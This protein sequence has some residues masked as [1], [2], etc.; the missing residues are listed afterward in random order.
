MSTFTIPAREVK[1]GSKVMVETVGG[2]TITGNVEHNNSFAGFLEFEDG[3]I[4]KYHAISRVSISPEERFDKPG[5]YV[6]YG[7]DLDPDGHMTCFPNLILRTQLDKK[8]FRIANSGDFIKPLPE[9]EV[10]YHSMLPL[11]IH[12]DYVGG[13]K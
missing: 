7:Y 5:V 9:S 2:A 1:A 6:Y 3:V 13:R 11:T 4:F 8:W 12:P 10:P